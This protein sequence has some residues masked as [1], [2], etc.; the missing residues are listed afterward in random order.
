MLR[1][2]DGDELVQI[3]Q[4]VRL[5][6]G[7]RPM[8]LLSAPLKVSLSVGCTVVADSEQ[9]DNALQR[10]D[11]ALYAAKKGGRD[12]VFYVPPIS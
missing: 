7:G 10:A 12:Q 5:F 11:S 6:I 2:K 1:V 8:Q 3:A 9:I 4:C